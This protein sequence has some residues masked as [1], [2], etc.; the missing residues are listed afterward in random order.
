MS[1]PQDRR[2][3][4]ALEQWGI[5]DLSHGVPLLTPIRSNSEAQPSPARTPDYCS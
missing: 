5:M 2:G 3:D 4:S 1:L